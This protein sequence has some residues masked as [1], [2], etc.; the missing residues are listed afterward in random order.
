MF[1]PHTHGLSTFLAHKACAGARRG[2]R[3]PQVTLSNHLRRLHVVFWWMGSIICQGIKATLPAADHEATVDSLFGPP[4]A[5][6]GGYLETHQGILDLAGKKPG[7]NLGE[8]PT[9][10]PVY[11]NLS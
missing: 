8:R 7:G 10:C 5:Y 3:A 11:Q 4:L 1:C 9:I 2:Q 6:I